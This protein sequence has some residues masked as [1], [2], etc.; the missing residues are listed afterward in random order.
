M[1]VRGNKGWN[2]CNVNGGRSGL[3]EPYF[4]SSAQAMIIS[5]RIE[6]E[7]WRLCS[8]PGVGKLRPA[9]RIWP[10]AL[11]YPARQRCMDVLN[12]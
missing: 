3:R 10:A 6:N 2:E 1:L 5:L 8:R 4:H 11:F 7:V 9:G 12:Q